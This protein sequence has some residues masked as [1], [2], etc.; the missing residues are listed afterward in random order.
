MTVIAPY[1]T[2]VQYTAPTTIPAAKNG[3]LLYTTLSTVSKIKTTG[4]MFGN[5]MIYSV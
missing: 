4:P 5:T 1:V 3:Q 2:A